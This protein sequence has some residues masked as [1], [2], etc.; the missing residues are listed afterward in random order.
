M[1]KKITA[2]LAGIFALVITA[3]A[4]NPTVSI[5]TTTPSIC[6]CGTV[7]YTNVSTNAPTSWTWYFPGGS[8]S[9]YYTTLSPGNPPA[10][11]YC[12]PGFYYVTC[13]VRNNFGKDSVTATNIIQVLAPPSVTITPPS[14][15]ICDTAGGQAF[16]TV[17]LQA[18]KNAAYT[19]SWAPGASLSNTSGSRVNAFPATTTVYTLTVTGVGGCTTVV[20]DTIIAGNVIAKITG[21]DSICQGFVDSLTASGGASNSAANTFYIWSNGK[22]TSTIAVS[23]SVTTTYSCTIRSGAGGCSSVA[24]FTVN[25]YPVPHFTISSPDSICYPGSA[26]LI[27]SPGGGTYQYFWFGPLGSQDTSNIWKV[28]PN[29]S[30]TYTLIVRNKGCYFDSLIKIKVNNPPVVYLSGA[31]NLCQGST[32][33]ICATGGTQ[34]HWSNGLG[35]T[36]CVDAKPPASITY[37]V[38]VTNGACFKDTTFTIIV[39]SMPFVKFKG[40]TSICTGDSTTIKVSGGLTYAW[41]TGNTTDSIHQV[42]PTAGLFTYF[43]TVTK[44]ACSKDSAKISVKVYP[45]PIPAAYPVD[46]T[47]CE[48]DTVQLTA[49]GGDYFIWSPSNTGLNHYKYYTNNDT[50]RNNAAPHVKTNYTVKVCTWGCCKDTTIT[51]N[52]IPGPNGTVCCDTVV[53]GGTPVQ[54][55]TTLGSG[56]YIVQGWAPTYGLNCSTCAD[57]IATVSKTTTYVVTFQDVLTLCTVKDSVTIDIFNCNVFV[58]NAFSPNKSYNNILRVRSECLVSLDFA[59]FDR[60]GNK[61]FETTDIN[62][63]WDG[64]YHGKKMDMGTYMWYLSGLEQDG[65]SVVRSGNTALVR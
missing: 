7:L 62:D 43:V 48:Y 8:P 46:T 17:Y 30:T 13:V 5:S 23:P 39:D 34:Y 3:Q 33:I 19:Y 20:T 57:P 25:P 49:A 52:I 37:T 65:T 9:T 18:T 54:L 47:V 10:I 31:T 35:S 59:V 28:S 24:F 26:T 14:G 38:Q 61:L 16:D 45:H 60:W 53:S 50:D 41:T 11:T 32:T 63:G 40:D 36:S 6:E 42:Y 12:T 44:G 15:G 4:Q 56:P 64:T 21:K 51:V 22:T 29:I 55:E 27:A 2:L 1:K 58:P